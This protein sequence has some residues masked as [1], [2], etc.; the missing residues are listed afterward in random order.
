M[1]KEVRAGEMTSCS[2]HVLGKGDNF[3]VSFAAK[4]FKL[5]FILSYASYFFPVVHLFVNSII[6]TT[7]FFVICIGKYSNI[8]I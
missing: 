1:N 5:T 2:T 7:Y 4:T 6:T 3:M 8:A